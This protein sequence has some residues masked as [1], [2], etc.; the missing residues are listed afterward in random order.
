MKQPYSAMVERESL[1]L[2]VAGSTPVTVI[3]CVISRN[4]NLDEVL[5]CFV[6]LLC[7][8]YKAAWRKGR[9]ICLKSLFEL[10]NIFKRRKYKR[11]VTVWKTNTRRKYK[12]QWSKYDTVR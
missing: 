2:K 12:F 5:F 10:R 7:L 3:F 6:I 8:Y 1:T 11:I 4:N 9:I